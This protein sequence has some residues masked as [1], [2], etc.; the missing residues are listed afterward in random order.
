MKMWWEVHRIE[1]MLAEDPTLSADE[2]KA[3]VRESAGH[4]L[5]AG[6]QFLLPMLSSLLWMFALFAPMLAFIIRGGVLNRL[7]GISVQDLG[8]HRASRVR[9]AGRSLLAWSPILIS[10][11]ILRSQGSIT[12]GANFLLA[13]LTLSVM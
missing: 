9:C 11:E 5:I 13:S 10:V 4:L 2:A 6:P 12:G 8:G 3:R 7:L 1:D